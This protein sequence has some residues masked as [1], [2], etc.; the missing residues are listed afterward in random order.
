MLT[1]G[2]L[3]RATLIAVGIGGL[4]ILTVAGISGLRQLA[5]AK[6]WEAALERQLIARQVTDRLMIEPAALNLSTGHGVS[7][8]Q[9]WTIGAGCDGRP[10]GSSKF[11]AVICQ[12]VINGEL[13]L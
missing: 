1:Y 6:S 2:S 11:A 4:L 13:Q 3:A 9:E 7:G 12:R 8:S 10:D 5:S